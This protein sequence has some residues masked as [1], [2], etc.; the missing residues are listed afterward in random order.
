MRNIE[1]VVFDMAGTVVNENNVVY[2]TLQKAINNKGYLLTLDFVLEHGAG[3]EKH[4]AIKDILTEEEGSYI[5]ALT[6]EIFQDFKQ[7]LEQEYQALEVTTY[8]GVE[9]LITALRK[10]G[11]KVAL[12]TGYD[13]NTAQ[14]LLYKM[15]W[16]LGVHYDALITAD[17]VKRGRPHPDMIFEAME[18]LKVSDPTHVLKAGDSIIDIEEGKNANCGITV[19]VTTGAHT[20]EQLASAKPTYVLNSLFDLKAILLGKK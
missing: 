12:N 13:N 15:K 14:L 17:D 20:R 7:L 4:Q 6:N 11:I 9:D 2:K 8:S 10:S 3:K 16:K 18:F 1:L 19:G 5:S